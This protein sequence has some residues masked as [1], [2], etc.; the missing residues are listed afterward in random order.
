MTRTDEDQCFGQLVR[1]PHPYAVA[2]NLSR[3]ECGI[4]SGFAGQNQLS[5][6]VKSKNITRT[7]PGELVSSAIEHCI[8]HEGEDSKRN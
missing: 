8:R 3:D 1:R 6:R 4:N 7:Q 2:D 5:K